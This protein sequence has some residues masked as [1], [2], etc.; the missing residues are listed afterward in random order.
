MI[1]T[2]H[3]TTQTRFKNRFY[4]MFPN[5]RNNTLHDLTFVL[6]VPSSSASHS[7]LKLILNEGYKDI[8]LTI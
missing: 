5:K 6:V 8:E 2:V 4:I 1:A 3:C 7:L